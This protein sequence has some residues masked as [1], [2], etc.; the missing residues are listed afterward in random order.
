MGRGSGFG[1]AVSVSAGAWLLLLP[2]VDRDFLG[3]HLGHRGANG[4]L[5]VDPG[6]LLHVIEHGLAPVHR[7]L[8]HDSLEPGLRHVDGVW[9][10]DSAAA[11]LLNF[12][13]V[14]AFLLGGHVNVDCAWDLL[15]HRNH[16]GALLGDLD[17]VL[18]LLLAESGLR[19]VDLVRHGLLSVF[20]VDVVDGAGDLLV[21]GHGD[22][23]LVS[24][25]LIASAGHL[26]LTGGSHE[27]S[28]IGAVFGRGR[29]GGGTAVAAAATAS[30][31]V[32]S[33]A[34]AARV[35][36]I[37]RGREGA[38]ARV[39]TATATAGV[40]AVNGGRK[41]GGTTVTGVESTATAAAAAAG[42]GV[43]SAAATATAGAITTSNINAKS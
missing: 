7:G 9:D 5:L 11:G 30:A 10:L 25:V 26:H 39:A 40:T 37:D 19:D 35:A 16:A 38:R 17:G 29:K 43:E 32:E 21:H 15:G 13:A 12:L 41:G 4:L 3:H 6:L 14:G 24:L 33:A 2:V 1:A 31:G 36:T 23:D 20:V 42:T 18:L 22:L 34:T 8:F 28:A 27:R